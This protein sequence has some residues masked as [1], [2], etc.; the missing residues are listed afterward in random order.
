M[1]R[2]PLS[3]AIATGEW[4]SLQSGRSRWLVECVNRN[5]ATFFDL[6]NWTIERK[7]SLSQVVIAP[8]ARAM[9]SPE[10]SVG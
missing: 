5:G 9:R 6:R 3:V 2:F 1:V 8:D 4:L 10:L 7:L